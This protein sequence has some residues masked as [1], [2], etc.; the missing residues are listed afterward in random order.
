MSSY[1]VREKPSRSKT[2]PLARMT[3]VRRKR[4]ACQPQRTEKDAY[5]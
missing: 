3:R 5:H 1:D 2:G 4:L